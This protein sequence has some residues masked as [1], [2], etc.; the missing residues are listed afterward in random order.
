MGGGIRSSLNEDEVEKNEICFHISIYLIH[1]YKGN[2]VTTARNLEMLLVSL[3]KQQTTLQYGAP[4][5]TCNHPGALVGREVG[6]L[7]C[8]QGREDVD[9][10][11]LLTASG[12]KASGKR[13]ASGTGLAL[14]SSFTSTSPITLFSSPTR[15]VVFP[16]KQNK[17]TN[18]D[19]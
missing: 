1:F 8:A 15:L 10:G 7:L 5:Q 18:S 19:A 12:A 14:A 11:E 6:N 2:A 16:T 13:L 3:T 9:T 17:E 4:C